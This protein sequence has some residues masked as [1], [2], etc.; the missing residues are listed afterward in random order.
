MTC[1][2]HFGYFKYILFLYQFCAFLASYI[3]HFNRSKEIYIDYLKM[4][5]K[6]NKNNKFLDNL[7]R[8]VVF[9][10]LKKDVL[11]FVPFDFALFAFIYLFLCC[12][13]S[14]SLFAFVFSSLFLLFLLWRLSLFNDIFTLR[15]FEL[16]PKSAHFLIW[17]FC[18]CRCC[19]SPS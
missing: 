5:E 14:S 1:P 17:A 8:N 4:L 19:C 10:S 6:N 12:C 3:S 13:C 2:T 7:N 18:C 11:F 9:F 15:F 16:M